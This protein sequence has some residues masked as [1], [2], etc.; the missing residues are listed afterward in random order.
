M[1]HFLPESERCCGSCGTELTKIREEKSEQ[2]EYIP[3]RF[4]VLEH[5]RGVYACKCCEETMQRA[6]KAPQAIEKGLPGPGLLAHIVVSK[7]GDHQPLDRR[8]N[9]FLRHGLEISRSTQCCWVA[10]AAEL[11][12]PLVSSMRLDLLRSKIIKTDDTTVTVLGDN[13]G[14][15]TGRLWVYIGDQGHPHL[16]FVYSP[17]REGRWPKDFLKDYRGYLQSDAYS[18]YDALHNSGITEVG[19]WSHTRRYF[20]EAFT[21]AKDKRAL[22]PLAWI[23]KLFRIEEDAQDLDAAAKQAMRQERARPVLDHLSQWMTDMKPKVLP[24][25]KL[26]KALTY[27]SNQ[28]EALARYV[29]NG[30]LCIDNNASE[31]AL[32]AV[33]IGRK[34]WMCAGSDQGGHR[35]AVFYSLIASAKANDVEPFAYLKSLFELLPTWPSDRLHELWPWAWKASHR[36]A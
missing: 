33:A 26:G 19:C 32:R 27:A 22:V 28:W 35:A 12:A 15:Y 24:K 7:Y 16:V 1:E 17:D 30:E 11:V 9:I 13:Q 6:P 5:V 18:G 25:S 31:R 34:N 8:Q 10:A 21:A 14:S 3:A 29:E 36:A 2:L 4:K 20:F 23:K